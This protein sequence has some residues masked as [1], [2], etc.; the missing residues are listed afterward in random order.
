MAATL[1]TVSTKS[2]NLYVDYKLPQACCTS[3]WWAASPWQ[4]SV[5]SKAKH[6][7]H[8]TKKNTTNTML[9]M[10]HQDHNYSTKATCDHAIPCNIMQKYSIRCNNIQYHA[11]QSIPVFIEG[12][13]WLRGATQILAQTRKGKKTPGKEKKTLDRSA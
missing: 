6:Q 3:L 13:F 5:L 10:I 12:F 1:K 4:G 2:N 11:C 7:T 8:V 9:N